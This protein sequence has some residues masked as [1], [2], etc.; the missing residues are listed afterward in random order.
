MVDA[1]NIQKEE[2]YI[3]YYDCFCGGGYSLTVLD[4]LIQRS[5]SKIIASDIDEKMLEIAKKNLSLLFKKWDETK[6]R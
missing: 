1:C 2:R 6:N 4:Y 5:I 3:V